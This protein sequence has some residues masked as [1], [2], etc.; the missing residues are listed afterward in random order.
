MRPTPQP[1]HLTTRTAAEHSMSQ[2]WTWLPVKSSCY[3][4]HVHAGFLPCSTDPAYT[5]FHDGAHSSKTDHVIPL[6]KALVPPSTHSCQNEQYHLAPP[7]KPWGSPLVSLRKWGI[8]QKLLVGKDHSFVS[9]KWPLNL[10]T[11]HWLL[12]AVLPTQTPHPYHFPMHT[13]EEA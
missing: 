12:K 2:K 7:S 9:T 6:H 5:P 4:C 10:R 13:V 8:K 1:Q 3:V 11:T